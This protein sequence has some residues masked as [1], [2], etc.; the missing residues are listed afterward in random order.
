MSETS[1]PKQQMIS[2]EAELLPETPTQ[3]PPRQ[4]TVAELL[5]KSN[6]RGAHL[7]AYRFGATGPLA[8]KPGRKPGSPSVRV[9]LTSAFLKTLEE[10]FEKNGVKTISRVRNKDPSTYVKI[11]AGLLPKQLEKVQPLEELSDAELAAGIALL[12]SKLSVNS[13]ELTQEAGTGAGETQEAEPVE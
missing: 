11:I 13:R 8:N 5:A 3:S 9:S 2:D 7:T 10:D 4:K 1:S 6:K 12:K